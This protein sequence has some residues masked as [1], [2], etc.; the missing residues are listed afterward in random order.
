MAPAGLDLQGV[1][2]FAGNVPHGFVLLP[3]RKHCVFPLG[4]T[5]VIRNVANPSEQHFL[6]G[7]SDNVTCL[8]VSPSG[9]YMASGQQTHMGFQ[10]DVI[11][12]DL[13]SLSMVHR[14]KLH[15]VKVEAIS[16]NC[17]ESYLA[18]LG[19]DDDL[20]LVIWDLQDGSA[21]CG[22]PASNKP[23]RAVQF[24]NHDPKALVTA[25]EQSLKLWHFDAELRK[26]K[27]TPCQLGKF[28]RTLISV[29]IDDD[30]ETVWTGTSSG[31]IMLVNLRTHL[32]KHIGPKKRLS[33]GVTV[34]TRA[35]N[36]TLLVG[37]GSGFIH[38]MHPDQLTVLK[39][40]E[41]GGGG[42]T[43]IAPHSSGTLAFVGTTACNTYVLKYADLSVSVRSTSHSSP[44]NCVAFPLGYSECFATA[45]FGEVRV[46]HARN[47][48]ELL[49]VSI[50]NLNCRVVTFATDGSAILSGW[51]DGKIRAFGPQSGKLLWVVNDAHVGG[52]SALAACNNPELMVSG[53]VDGQVRIWRVSNESRVMLGSMKEHKGTVTCIRVR[54]N[55]SECVSCSDDGSAL[56]WDLQSF[57]R[58]NSLFASTFF[59]AI[60]YHPDESQ[61]ITTG[62]DRKITNWDATDGTAIRI[63][64]GSASAEV[65]ALSMGSSGEFFI[66]GGGDRLL[67]CW[68]YDDGVVT[69]VG[70]GHSAGINAVAVSPD[71]SQFVSV[72]D[73]GAIFLWSCPV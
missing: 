72:G 28:S 66:S 30:D 58:S 21:I 27:P 11:V 37:T 3:D 31:D 60:E 44:V 39:T 23:V 25:G 12:W 19:G 6:Q 52:V 34:I 24:L 8:T 36:G 71:Q 61:L 17:D 41:V 22:S 65:N 47:Q 18:T 67:K 46:W 1:I 53:G 9:R 48:N 64:D 54:S 49:R 5:V 32:F 42:I 55:D 43:S 13:E 26:V 69:H 14:L 68:N 29:L 62:T 70:A 59:R 33:L 15:K 56:V 10:A 57:H 38:M 4:S 16:F 40:V 20:A 50:P 35:P 63:V 2:G 51:S 45:S 73:E 7:H